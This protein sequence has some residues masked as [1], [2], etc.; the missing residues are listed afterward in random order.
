MRIQIR[1]G[2]RTSIICICL[3][4]V[5]GDVV[6]GDKAKDFKFDQAM[7]STDPSHPA[8]AGQVLNCNPIA[9]IVNK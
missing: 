9:D 6:G 2:D 8:F 3:V 4:S 5:V 7:D 1:T